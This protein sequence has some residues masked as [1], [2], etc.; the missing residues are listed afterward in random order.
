M[1]ASGRAI[2]I[3]FECANCGQHTTIRLTHCIDFADPASFTHA[4][5]F[6]CCQ[7]ETKVLIQIGYTYA[8][9]AQTLTEKPVPVKIR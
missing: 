4:E 9:T 3:Q 7:C 2:C 5:V 1:L 8:A 6:V